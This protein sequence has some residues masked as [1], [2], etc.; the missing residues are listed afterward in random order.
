MD[1]KLLWLRERFNWMGSHSGYDQV[2][3]AIAKIKINNYASVY[4]S[5]EK[6]PS[7]LTRKLLS[8]LIRDLKVSPHYN[9]SNFT[10]EVATFWASLFYKPD[11]IHLSYVESHLGFLP[12]YKTKSSHPWKLIG[13]AHQPM[14]WWRFMHTHPDSISGLDALI[15]PAQRE[16]SYFEQF[17]GDRV[18]FVRHG[19]DLDFFHPLSI[20]DRNMQNLAN[21]RCVFSGVWL[22]DFQALSQVIELVLKK[23]PHIYFDLIINQGTRNNQPEFFRMARHDQVSWHANISDQKLCSLYQQASALVFPLLDCTANNALVEAIAC[24][25]P[26]ISNDLSGVRDYTEPSFASLFAFGDIDGMA[27][28]VLNLVDDRQ[29]CLRRGTAA[30]LYAEQNLCWEQI[31]LQTLDVYQKTLSM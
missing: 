13:T 6:K 22:R 18:H 30:R 2:F 25:V 23:N 14:S 10:A 28:A 7:R 29:E 19:V 20:T 26:I 5:L 4:H 31:A 24:G 21:P 27:N 8:W 12:A 3:E 11:L 1:Y 16:V 9:S 17:L 15:V